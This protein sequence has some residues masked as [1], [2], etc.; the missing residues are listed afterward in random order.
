MPRRITAADLR[1]VIVIERDEA[2]DNTLGERESNWVQ[3]ARLYACVE[4]LRGRESFAAGQMQSPQDVRFTV[5]F[6]RSL[7]IDTAMRVR[8]SDGLYG[9]NAVIDVDG[10]HQW[11]ELMCTQ[12]IRDGR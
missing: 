3:H 11:L 2:A 9:I 12:G 6:V 10:A 4:P 7:V 5:R 1:S 8:W